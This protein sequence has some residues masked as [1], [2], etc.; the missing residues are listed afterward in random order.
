MKHSPV[1]V[2]QHLDESIRNLV[3]LSRLFVLDPNKDFTRQRT[4]TLK[5]VVEFLLKMGG[6]TLNKELLD[7]FNFSPETVTSS[8]FIQQRD[9]LLSDGLSFLFHD[10]THS[11]K[12]LETYRG[13]RLI[14][15]DGTGCSIP[16]NKKHPFT[17]N[18]KKD[19]NEI[20]AVA[21]YDVCNHIFIDV[22]LRGVKK[23]N[24]C[25]ASVLMM[26]RSTISE[27]TILLG[28]RGFG[29][30]NNLAHLEQKGWKFLFRTKNPKHNNNT[31]SAS[32]VPIDEEFDLD[33][34]LKLTRSQTAERK[35]D[36]GY[37]FL[38]KVGTL[39][40]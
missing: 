22:V 36:K 29:S 15:V 27:P 1:I 16:K 11:F 28:D 39:I 18:N 6:N 37:R 25:R 31:L 21:F 34:N 26:E 38:P 24:E 2:K 5:K 4:F 19:M 35:K 30:Y 10:F 32:K 23:K 40:F 3:S 33:I 17:Y 13:Y 12:E 20:Y 14:A 9:K 8:A 7:Y